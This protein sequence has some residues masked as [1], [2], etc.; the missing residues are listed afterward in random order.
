LTK[1]RQFL[2]SEAYNPETY[3]EFLCKIKGGSVDLTKDEKTGIATII[4]NN[5]ERK[6]AISGMHA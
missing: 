3:K 4:L 5:P 2:S 6:N 1:R